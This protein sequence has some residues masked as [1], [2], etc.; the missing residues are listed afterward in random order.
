MR[1]RFPSPAPSPA[2]LIS[3]FLIFGDTLLPN[4]ALYHHCLAFGRNSFDYRAPTAYSK[5]IVSTKIRTGALKSGQRASARINLRVDPPLKAMLVRAARAQRLKLTEFMVKSSQIAAEMALTE[6]TRFV[7]PPDKWREFNAALD[8]PARHIPAL[9]K[10]FTAA[11][12][13]E[14]T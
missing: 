12:I 6:R 3:S 14:T 9:K 10:V 11:S 8:A 5:Y 1:V 4:I 2:V 13:F 7:L